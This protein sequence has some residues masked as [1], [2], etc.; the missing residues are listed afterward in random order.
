M[1]RLT[2]VTAL[3]LASNLGNASLET[4]CYF[5]GGYFSTTYFA[6]SYF[7]ESCTASSSGQ[8]GRRLMRFPGVGE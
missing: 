5:A 7:D 6:S 4:S 8:K 1:R 2:A 3:L